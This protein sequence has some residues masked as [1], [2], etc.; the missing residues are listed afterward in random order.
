ML[1][2]QLYPYIESYLNEYLYGFTKDQL[3]I[4]VA[5]G[6]IKFENLNLRPDT[7]NQKMDEKNF[8]FWLKA[9]LV[10]KINIGLGIMNFIGEKP[11]DVLI[12][13]VN[14]ILNPSYKWIIKNMDSFIIENINMMKSVYD[15]NDNNSIDI[16]TKKINVLDNSIFKKEYIE[17]IFKDK[18]RLSIEINKIFKFCYKYF[19]SNN[20]LIN[21]TIK[22]IHIRFEDDQVI[23]YNGNLALGVRLDSLEII[24]S[25]EGVQKRDSL[26]INKLNVY[27]ES[28][29]KILIPSSALTIKIKDGKLDEEYYTNLKKL[30]FKNFEYSEN[31]KFLIQNFS[32]YVKFGIKSVNKGKIDIFD[33]GKEE[34]K[35]YLQFI[36]SEINFHFYPDLLSISQNFSKFVNEFTVLEQVQDFK[37][38]KKP[39]NIKD[40]TYL[41]YMDFM[42]KTTNPK[43]IKNFTRKKK[44][45]VRDWLFYF[46]WCQKCKLSLI[47]KKINPLRLEFSRFYNLCFSYPNELFYNNNNNNNNNNFLEKA[48]NIASSIPK[49]DE[50]KVGIEDYNPDKINISYISDFTIKGLNINLH[51][52]TQNANLDFISIKINNIDIKIMLNKSKFDLML[53]FYSIIIGPNK[54]SIGEKVF[55][56]S[57]RK[58]KEKEQIPSPYNNYNNYEESYYQIINNIEENTG[59]TGL[60]NKYNPNYKLKLQIIDE[61]LEKIGRN[62]KNKSFFN[63]NSN[64]NNNN[65]S[66]ININNDIINDNISQRNDINSN[67]SKYD[68]DNKSNTKNKGK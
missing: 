7:L 12:E 28:P 52:S 5:N 18:T 59:L 62:N 66:Q 38:L 57:T 40:R 26:K 68:I 4:G 39:Y 1:K 25:S 22:N 61:A 27:W 49:T 42:N 11:L 29:A 41:E 53:N 23:N 13:G 17:E 54:L 65:E 64:N 14:V 37:P 45:L 34:Y 21:L 9:G 24:L 58:K 6:Q 50:K 33:K 15:P 32:F 51:P 36:S 10:S 19:Y 47:G 30:N 2:N 60:V 31:N 63:Y 48:E 67:D 8:P 3:N 16:F 44:M 35:F 20:F 55:L 56:S 43:Y 46:Y